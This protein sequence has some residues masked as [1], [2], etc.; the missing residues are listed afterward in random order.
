MGASEQAL[1]QALGQPAGR[2]DHRHQV[3]HELPGQAELPRQQPRAGHGVDRQ[4]P[5]APRHRLVDVYIVHWPDRETPFEETMGALDDVVQRRQGPPRRALELQARGDRGVPGR[6]AGSTSCSTGGTCSTGACSGRSCRYCEEH[7][8]GVHGVR[9]AGLR[10]AD[11]AR[12]PRRPASART[13]GGR[14]PAGAW[15]ACAS[16]TPCSARSG[17]PTTRRAPA[18]TPA[19][20][21]S[22]PTETRWSTTATASR[23]PTTTGSDERLKPHVVFF[24]ENV[25][26]DRV[27]RAIALV[28]DSLRALLVVGSSLTVMSGF[29]FVRQAAR[30]GTPVVI[31]NRNPDPGRRP[32]RRT[33]RRRLHRDAL[34]LVETLGR[35]RA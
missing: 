25:P 18:P 9:V 13:T 20:S 12:S 24:G 21:R 33:R 8:I 6:S 11:R 19:T 31:V 22:H 29:R 10:P 2:G 14:G 4:E 28:D 7:G 16:S 30:A 27:A 17:S 35:V 23:W 1:G 3:R 5:E 26:R 32:G 15:P 34:R